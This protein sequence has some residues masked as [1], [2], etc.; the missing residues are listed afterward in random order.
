MNTRSLPAVAT[1]KTGRQIV[2]GLSRKAHFPPVHARTHQAFM[3]PNSYTTTRRAGI[4]HDMETFGR[5]AF[6]QVDA[7]FAKKHS[8]TINKDIATTQGGFESLGSN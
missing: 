3:V 8:G 1:K 4:R 7:S 5:A 2:E 6:V